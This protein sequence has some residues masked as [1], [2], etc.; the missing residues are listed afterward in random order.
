[1]PQLQPK[2]ALSGG[3]QVKKALGAA[4]A[5]HPDVLLLDEPPL[6]WILTPFT[7]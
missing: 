7:G 5:T 2:A 3:E 6:I 1:M 4:L